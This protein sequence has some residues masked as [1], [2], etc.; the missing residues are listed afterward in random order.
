MTKAAILRFIGE[1]ENKLAELR[2]V[3][4]KLPEAAEARP[5]NTLADLEQEE[6][7]EE[8]NDLSEVFATL[9]AAW[10]IPPDVEPD[11]PLEELQKAMAEGLPENWA[12]R[13]I[14]RMREE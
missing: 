8:A 11:M 13:E 3:V 7:E 12:S 14:M 10:N 6:T 9:R 4:K 1:M 5:A 2:A